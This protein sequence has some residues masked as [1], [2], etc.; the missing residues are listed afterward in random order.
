MA[1]PANSKSS[2]RNFTMICAFLAGA[3]VFVL[4]QTKLLGHKESMVIIGLWV[5]LMRKLAN[6]TLQEDIATQVQ[7]QEQAK[8]LAHRAAQA[9]VAAGQREEKHRQKQKSQPQ[10]R[11]ER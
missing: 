7:A 11:K 5:L 9:A 10:N 3:A 6:E 2:S 1:P 8:R 4:N